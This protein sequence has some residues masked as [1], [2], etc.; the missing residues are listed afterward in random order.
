MRGVTGGRPRRFLRPPVND[1]ESLDDGAGLV[2]IN[3]GKA[4]RL[5]V[6]LTTTVSRTLEQ[7]LTWS[8]WRRRQRH[9]ARRAHF[10]RR[11]GSVTAADRTDLRL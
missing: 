9:R 1:A 2:A 4:R 10:R 6:A 5:F 7:V 8:R 3:L 11:A